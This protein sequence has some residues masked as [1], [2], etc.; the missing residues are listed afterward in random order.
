V[1][2]GGGV[3]C[4]GALASAMRARVGRDGATVFTPTPRLATDNAAMI[5]RAAFFRFERGERAGLDL[6]AFASCPI[7]GLVAA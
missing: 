2:L 7:P 6:N 4:N 3:A 5:A 1:V